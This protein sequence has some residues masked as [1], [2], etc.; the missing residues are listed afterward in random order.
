MTTASN[1]GTTAFST[2][3]DTASITVTGVNDAPVITSN[4]EGSSAN[5]NVT[6]GNTTVT[7][8]TASDVDLPA[9]TLSFSLVGGADQAFFSIQ[10]V[11]G[12]KPR[13]LL[14]LR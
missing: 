7:T 1:G 5:V 14:A 6:E 13:T 11:R 10:S 8:V 3:T 9:D 12:I 4:G 2:A